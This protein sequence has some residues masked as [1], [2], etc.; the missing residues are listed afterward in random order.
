NTLYRYIRLFGF[1]EKLGI[2]LPGETSGMIR[3]PKEWSKVSI[4]AIPIGHEVGVTALQLVSAISVI[5][6]G[7][8]LMRPYI[9]KEIRD[10]YGQVIKSNLP[11]FIRKVISEETANRAKKVLRGVVEKGTAKLAESKEFTFAGKTGT[12]QKINPDGTYSHSR[13]VASFIGFAPCDNPQIS[14][15]II[16]D[17]PKG[18]YYGGLVAAPAFKNIAEDTLRYLN[19]KNIA[20]NE[21]KE[22]S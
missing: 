21:T 15:A 14:V 12:A 13:Y 17:E 16:V 18:Y 2:D 22:A 19:Q 20:V 1:G 10:K 8:K 11:I 3:E 4:S 5:A 9:V 6:N 7:G